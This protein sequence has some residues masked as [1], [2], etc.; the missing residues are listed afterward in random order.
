MTPEERQR[1]MDFLLAQQPRHDHEM[2]KSATS[3]C[4]DG[5][6]AETEPIFE[7]N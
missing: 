1:Q 7:K 3:C 4:L 6:R 2:P 5:L